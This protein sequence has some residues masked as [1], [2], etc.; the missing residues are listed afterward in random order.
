MKKMETN[1]KDVYAAGDI[2]EFDNCV[3]VV[4]ERLDR[5]GQSRRIQYCG[6]GIIH[7]ILL[8]A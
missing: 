5:T 4:L 1:T 6:R 2:A 3:A 7:I 8:S